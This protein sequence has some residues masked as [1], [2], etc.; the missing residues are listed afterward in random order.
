M[1]D[2]R[3]HFVLVAS[4]QKAFDG[5]PSSGAVCHLLS[6]G[7]LSLQNQNPRRLW[8]EGDFRIR[9]TPGFILGSTCNSLG[10]LGRVSK[11]LLPCLIHQNN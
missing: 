1:G 3:R 2:S 5:S 9:Q 8:W 10:D 4:L 6:Q 7:R 11:S